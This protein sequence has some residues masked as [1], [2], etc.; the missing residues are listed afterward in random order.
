[1]TT[2]LTPKTL[3][4][5]GFGKHDA[6]VLS[7]LIS[8]KKAVSADIEHACRLRQPEVCLSLGKLVEDG[9]VTYTKKKKEGK[10]RPV[11]IYRANGKILEKLDIK[12]KQKQ[13]ESEENIKKLDEISLILKKVEQEQLQKMKNT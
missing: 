7:H 5:I 3:E 1:M 11:H 8:M 4:P 6:V 13:K 12:L 10:G 9:F 2:L